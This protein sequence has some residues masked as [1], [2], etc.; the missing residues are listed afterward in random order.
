VAVTA[1][2]AT[3]EPSQTANTAR[4]G[5][6]LPLAGGSPAHGATAPPSASPETKGLVTGD[7]ASATTAPANPI[8]SGSAP[9]AGS[10]A[11][12]APRD[13]ASAT[14]DQG[15]YLT[16][17][18]GSVGSAS[19][20]SWTE[21]DVTV[22]LAKPV[23]QLQ[24]IVRVAPS[25]GLANTGYTWINHDTSVFDVTVAPDSGGL[26]FTFRLKPGQS[27]AAGQIEFGAQFGHTSP[28]D[29]SGDTYAASVT[30]NLPSGSSAAVSQGSF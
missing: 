10:S 24:L 22:T 7:G 28:H 12:S 20:P 14:P 2:V 9:V 17:A 29:P 8:G 26:T 19:N 3:H 13:P 15:T 30:S 6:G 18:Q 23:D 5:A 21:L 1:T 16:S 11:S 4:H 25:A 27:L